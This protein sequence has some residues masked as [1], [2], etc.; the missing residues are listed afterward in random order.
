M[1][2]E[3]ALALCGEES[4]LSFLAVCSGGDD[5]LGLERDRGEAALTAARARAS[6]AG[7]ASR[8]L[9]LESAHPSR[10][11]V[12]RAPAHDLLVIGAHG[13]KGTEGAMLGRTAT[14]AA[15]RPERAVLI[16]RRSLGHI[17][18]PG[19]LLFATDGSPSSWAAAKIASALGCE[20]RPGVRVIYASEDNDPLRYQQVI[21]QLELIEAE[22]GIPLQVLHKP[23][24]IPGRICQAA[25]SGHSSLI[26][27]GH[28]ASAATALSRASELVIHHAPC[29]VLVAPPELSQG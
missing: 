29:S 23:G 6:L 19:G 20:A 5:R 28:S 22:T 14:A 10:T 3:Q 15:H 13:G 7:V 12:E 27:I 2:V 8:G 11:I 4:E 1:A 16:A 24:A 25:E 26:V 21:R 17:R 18:F 9:L